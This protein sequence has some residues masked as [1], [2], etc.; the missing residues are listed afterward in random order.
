MAAESSA[1]AAWTIVDQAWLLGSPAGTHLP[2]PPR[3]HEPQH[4]PLCCREHEVHLA[5]ADAAISCTRRV[6]VMLTPG[7]LWQSVRPS[8]STSLNS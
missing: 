8:S 2:V 4:C 7:C 6:Q 1:R 5:L 3:L